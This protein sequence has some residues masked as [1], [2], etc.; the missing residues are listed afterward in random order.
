MLLHTLLLYWIVLG[1]ILFPIQLLVSAPY[2]RHSKKTWGVMIPNKLGWV[3]MESWALIAFGA[4]YINYFS[5]NA[6]ALFFSVLYVL[7][8]INRSFIFP[9]RT[10]TTG[11]QM[12]LLIV[13]SAMLFNSVNASVIAY[14]TAQEQYP[15]RYFL[16]WNFITGLILFL[17][18][19]YI[20]NKA[21]TL[22]IN[23]R[24]PNET[25]YKI[26]QGFLFKYISCPNLLGEIIEWFGFALLI[27]NIA[28]WAFLVWTVSNLLP[29]AW[30]HHKWYKKTFP[31]YPIKRKAVIPFV[32]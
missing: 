30:H 1:I 16:Q 24:K 28:G 3:L 2:G 22:L 17:L 14:Y 8:Y 18:G 27:W 7:H 32:V 19:F 15:D 31:D 5:V 20:N 9:I 11:K 23:L 6:Y 29:R 12:P 13:L 10:H 25:G 4:V 26:P 21:D